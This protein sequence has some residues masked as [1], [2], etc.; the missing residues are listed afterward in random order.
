[1]LRKS[2]KI[3][4]N[5]KLADHHP[6]IAVTYR[7]IESDYSN[8]GKY[9][10]AID[11]YDKSFQINLSAFGDIHP[12]ITTTYGN[13]GLVYHCLDNYENAAQSP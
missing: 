11:M 4:F 3:Q 13:I 7:Y 5:R 1:M 2:H 6:G 12:N 8:Q 10:D 9:D